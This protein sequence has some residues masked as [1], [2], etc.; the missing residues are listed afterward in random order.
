MVLVARTDNPLYSL[1]ALVPALL[2][3]FLDSYYLGMEKSFRKSYECLV[4]KLV[5]DSLELNDLYAVKPTNL[6]FKEKLSVLGSYAIF[7]FYLAAIAAII[8]MY[9]FTARCA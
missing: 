2:F 8:L 9:F 6:T 1:I 4:H 7:P 3:L 5:N